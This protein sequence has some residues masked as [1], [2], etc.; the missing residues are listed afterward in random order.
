[1]SGAQQG[2]K[3]VLEWPMLHDVVRDLLQE[4]PDLPEM[5]VED[6][7]EVHVHDFGMTSAMSRETVCL[8]CR[9]NKTLGWTCASSVNVPSAFQD[10]RSWAQACGRPDPR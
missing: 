7:V 4:F 6:V 5:V 10:D 3:P 9:L 1:M 8:R 2:I